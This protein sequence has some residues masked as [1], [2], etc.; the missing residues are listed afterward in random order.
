MRLPIVANGRQAFLPL[1]ATL[2]LVA[3]AC[4]QQ[5]P[6]APAAAPTS[7]PAAAA[8]TSAPAAGGTIQFAWAG[9]LTGDVAQLGQGYL[10]GIKMAAEEWNAK[11]GVLGKQIDIKPEDDACDPKQ[12]GTVATKIADDTNNVLVF[13]HFCSGT[14]LA[15][16]PIYNKIN[17]PELTI[18]SNP[19]I[20]QQGWKNLF[21]PQPNDNLQGKA[22]VQFVMKKTGAKKFAMLSDKQ[23]FGEGVVEV[24]KQTVEAAG[25]TVTSVGGVEPKDV[26]Y[27]AV[28][29]KIIQ[30]EDPDAIVYCTN[31]NTSAG[32]MAKQVR[33]LGFK[34][35]II[36]CDGWMDPGMV[37]AAGDAANFVSDA[38]AVYWTFQV[39]PYDI[40][41]KV[42]DFATKYKAKYGNDPIGYEIYGYDIG[43]LAFAAVNNAGSVD[44]DKV[45]ASLKKGAPG[46][47][48]DNYTFD[49]NGDLI[50][51]PIYVYTV[52]NGAW[53][54]KLVDTIK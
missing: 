1:V 10:N 51:A 6:Q 24:A 4:A 32:L 36:G 39:P 11:G 29:T 19:K 25:G 13:G 45:I 35:P 2:A 15:A 7:A 3:S 34:K 38:E 53:P 40:N 46:V 17:L 12:A 14:T 43:N 9:P 41:P 27:S 52:E 50:G 21:R 18:S 28:L 22:G 49:D 5:Q 23:A 26:D 16:G 47:L 33:Q 42:K 37:K 30:T 8:P 54:P 31:F 44:H 20:T 48:V